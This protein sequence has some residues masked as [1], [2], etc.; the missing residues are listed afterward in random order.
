MEKSK[1][2]PPKLKLFELPQEHFAIAGI[3]SA[4]ASQPY[5]FNAAVLS[6]FLLLALSIYMTSVFLIYD[7]ETFAEYTQSVYTDTL[8]TLIIFALL[9]LIL[10]VKSLF[11]FINGCED[12]ASTSECEYQILEHKKH[13]K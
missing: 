9:I 13:S 6:G 5:P 8:L 1:S 7:A 4:L 3:T 11:E 2:Q 10:K 12:L